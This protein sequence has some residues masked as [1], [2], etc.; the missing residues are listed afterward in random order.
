MS[1]SAFTLLFGDQQCVR[2]RTLADSLNTYQ[3]L[4]WSKLAHIFRL[5]IQGTPYH[6]AMAHA[7]ALHSMI[8][9]WGQEVRGMP[10]ESNLRAALTSMKSASP[11]GADCALPPITSPLTQR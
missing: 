5:N 9:D 8:E 1:R 3:A 10:P 11:P 4:N 6:R 7:D 2:T